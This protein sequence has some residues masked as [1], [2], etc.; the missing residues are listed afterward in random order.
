LWLQVS[1]LKRQL[2]EAK[3]QQEKLSIELQSAAAGRDNAREREAAQRATAEQLQF[4]L[5][6]AHARIDAASSRV[7]PPPVSILEA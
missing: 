5:D 2:A 6:E 7:R 4:L 3:A 1:E